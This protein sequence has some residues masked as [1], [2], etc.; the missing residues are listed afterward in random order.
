MMENW[1]G[2]SGGVIVP[3]KRSRVKIQVRLCGHAESRWNERAGRL[4][5][6]LSD[7]IATLLVERI[8][9]GLTVHHGRAMLPLSAQDLNLPEDLVA[10]IDLPDCQGIWRVVTFKPLKIP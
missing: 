9:A 3:R 5:G 8:R 4:P 6:R 1:S 7:L 2:G 10:C